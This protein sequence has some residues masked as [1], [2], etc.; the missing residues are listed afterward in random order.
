MIRKL[1]II[2][3][4]M[5]TISFS[6]NSDKQ[7]NLKTGDVKVNNLGTI[8]GEFVKQIRC[9][10]CDSLFIRPDRGAPN[11]YGRRK[12][13]KNVYID[14]Y[15]SS[16]KWCDIIILDGHQEWNASYIYFD[17]DANVNKDKYMSCKRA[18]WYEKKEPIW[19]TYKINTLDGYSKSVIQKCSWKNY[20]SP[21]SV[22]WNAEII[23]TCK[24]AYKSKKVDLYSYV[25]KCQKYVTIE[26][27]SFELITEKCGTS[28]VEWSDY[29]NDFVS[30]KPYSC[31]ED[32]YWRYE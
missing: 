17:E 24:E 29:K 27:P 26:Y 10:D 23:Q 7:W 28:I 20:I 22:S 13:V 12:E 14:A 31:N 25:D 1:F 4:V 19:C 21:P 18:V 2:L 3:T 30:S 9:D 8:Q 5:I 6:W 15:D 11:Y 32:S 16:G